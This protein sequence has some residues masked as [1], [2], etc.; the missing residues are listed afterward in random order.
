MASDRGAKAQLQTKRDRRGLKAEA[1]K[2]KKYHVAAVTEEADHEK[3][4][5]DTKVGSNAFVKIKIIFYVSMF[6][7]H[8][9]QGQ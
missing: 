2:G 3:R 7:I 8:S 1:R 4:G 6:A 5:T 9:F